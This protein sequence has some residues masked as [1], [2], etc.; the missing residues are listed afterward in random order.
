MTDQEAEQKA[1]KLLGCKLCKFKTRAGA[2]VL[3]A[4]TT[5]THPKKEK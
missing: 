3:A 1:P 2:K 5:I 4:H